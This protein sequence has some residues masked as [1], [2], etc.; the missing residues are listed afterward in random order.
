V[1]KRKAAPKKKSAAARGK[2]DKAGQLA[3]A[4]AATA[5]T[6]GEVEIDDEGNVVDPNETRYCLCNGVSFG[7]MIACENADVSLILALDPF[8]PLSSC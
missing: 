2:K 3:N 8:I 5:N 7:T 6:D 1:G 4:D